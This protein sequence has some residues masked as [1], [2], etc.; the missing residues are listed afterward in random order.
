M[1]ALFRPLMLAACLPALALPAPA[2]EEEAK[3]GPFMTL[4]GF[5][6]KPLA[7]NDPP[8][9]KQAPDLPAPTRFNRAFDRPATIWRASEGTF[10]SYLAGESGGGLF[11]AEEKATGWEMLVDGRVEQLQHL[12]NKQYLATG[13]T[14]HMERMAGAAH[15]ISMDHSGKWQVRKIYESHLGVP[16]IIGT[17]TFQAAN[18]AAVPLTVFELDTRGAYPVDAIQGVTPEGV[19]HYLGR[20]LKEA[21]AAVPGHV[22]DFW[23][24]SDV[25]EVKAY[26]FDSE[27][28][29][30][31]SI[32][33]DGKLHPGAVAQ[34]GM[35][36]AGNQ[37]DR[38]LTAMKGKEGRSPSGCYEPHHGFVFHDKDGKV[39]A[40]V[41]VSLTCK[42]GV[43]YPQATEATDWD[44]EAIT[45][46]LRE[47]GLPV[48]ANDEE[49]RRAFRQ[50]TAFRPGTES[51][52]Q[53]AAQGENP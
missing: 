21:T 35:R 9:S 29:K 26:L 4:G 3:A 42:N 52:A 16:H 40:H 1:R 13:G 30:T 14:M 33:E 17:T 45:N 44:M 15:L 23:S 38:L 10:V 2:G 34:L 37:P 12:G 6:V 32:I 36:L 20:R 43:A 50:G 25:H 51:G 48:L 22:S 8:T 11:F 31:R 47:L 53:P 39:L 24:A 7:G 18:G 41:T 19:I 28:G 27:K 49:Y 46:I 5:E